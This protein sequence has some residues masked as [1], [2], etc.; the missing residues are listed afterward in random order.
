MDEIERQGAALYAALRDRRPIPPLR[1]RVPGLDL[2]MAY[3]ISSAM[4]RRRLAAG[5]RVVGRKIGVTSAA[6]QQMLGVFEPDFGT[7]TDTM[8]GG[9]TLPI[10]TTLIQPRAEGE[11]ALRLSRDLDGADTS[12]EAVEAAIEAVMPCFEIVDSRIEGWRIGIED[13]VADNASSGLF[14]VG[15]A[16]SPAGFDWEGCEM[17]VWKNGAPLSQG[18]G[19]AALGSPL[20]SAAWLARTL[21][22]FGVPLRAGDIVL[23]GSLVPLE[24]VVAGDRMALT[25]SGAGRLEVCFT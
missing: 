15:E 21:A 11:I 23:T 12:P 17:R 8:M 5:E 18:F 25:L 7:L 10:S 9:T 13:T 1:G 2:D 24:P 4:L 16:A 6:V 22:R 14:V 19:R 20:R 3:A